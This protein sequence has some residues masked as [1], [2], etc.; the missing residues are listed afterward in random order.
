MMNRTLLG[1]LVV[2]LMLSTSP[3]V[4]AATECSAPDD[5][6]CEL[7]ATM[8]DSGLNETPRGAYSEAPEDV[9]V[10]RNR[11]YTV[12]QSND[13]QADSDVFI[14]K[15]DAT[16]GRLLWSRR[17]SGGSA[18]RPFD[19]AESVTVSP[20]GSTIYVAGTRRYDFQ[21]HGNMFLAAF[22]ARSGK[23]LWAKTV[24]RGR[25][26]GVEAEVAGSGRAVYVTGTGRYEGL[27]RQVITA[28][29]N[30]RGDRIWKRHYGADGGDGVS[31]LAISASGIFVAASIDQDRRSQA[32]TLSY[33]RRGRLK[34]AT[35]PDEA[36]R[37]QLYGDDLRV[38]NGLVYRLITTQELEQEGG[39]AISG[40]YALGEETGELVWSDVITNVKTG[41]VSEPQLAL[42]PDGQV[43]YAVGS[44]GT[45]PGA[46]HF[47][48]FDVR[49]YDAL[50]GAVLWTVTYDHPSADVLVNDVMARDEGV[51]IGAILLPGF[52][53]DLL[54]F[55]LSRES[56]SLMWSARHNP[57][58][59]A[60]SEVNGGT[61]AL[62][63]NHSVIHAGEVM[64]GESKSG[65]GYGYGNV[66]IAAYE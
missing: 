13:G 35:A 37:G 66:V 22:S 1:A 8:W 45:A 48:R 56:G 7:W 65:S 63:P 24:H 20:D 51:V 16:T 44:P 64:Y 36:E 10:H 30:A 26:W 46:D 11:L 52:G 59:E 12:G 42:S 33:S 28:R 62:G 50:S 3:S 61:M 49:A 27:R 15:S 54:T 23:K 38:V 32:T 41:F 19:R 55:A 34:W 4:T 39:P 29:Y 9:A 5:N 40:M 17:F 18:K 43:A 47:E 58:D 31:D 14:L 2:A 57:S 6:R 21:G 60:N 53:R 25:A